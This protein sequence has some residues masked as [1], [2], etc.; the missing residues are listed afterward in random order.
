MTQGHQHV[1]TDPQEADEEATL[2]E[3]RQNPGEGK[4]KKK[5]RPP[6]GGQGKSREKALPLRRDLE[7]RSS[8]QIRTPSLL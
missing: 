6:E 7:Q 3:Q 8:E 5:T 1:C 4:K 2:R